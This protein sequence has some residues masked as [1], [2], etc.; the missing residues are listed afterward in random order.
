[1][2]WKS[3]ALWIATICPYLSPEEEGREERERGHRVWTEACKTF[4]FHSRTKSRII[5][6]LCTSLCLNTCTGCIH[7]T[8]HQFVLQIT[9]SVYAAV[10]QYEYSCLHCVHTFPLV[11]PIQTLLQK[12]LQRLPVWGGSL[13]RCS[14]CTVLCSC[15]LSASLNRPSST[16]V[17]THT[18]TH[19]QPRLMCFP[20]PLPLQLKE[21]ANTLW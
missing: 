19:T 5:L 1:M 11:I 4:I 21:G 9:L 18:N 7:L 15:G 3:R 13:L 17:H 10:F 20:Q 8:G 16:C 14:T 2:K 6:L 12:H